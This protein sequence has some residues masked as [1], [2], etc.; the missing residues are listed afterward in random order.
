MIL[1]C[2]GICFTLSRSTSVTVKRLRAVFE[3][4]GVH[5]RR[6][7]FSYQRAVTQSAIGKEVYKFQRH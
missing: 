4:T 6:S 5:L 3:I 1:F 7:Y 2:P